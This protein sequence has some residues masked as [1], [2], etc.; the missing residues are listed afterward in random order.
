MNDRASSLF[1]ALALLAGF[2]LTGCGRSSGPDRHEHAAASAA[3]TYQCP[4]H[5]WI[6]SDKADAK[7]TICGMALVAAS[8]TTTSASAAVDPNLVTLTPAQAAV[9]GV[10]TSPVRRGT[11]VRTLRVTGAIDDDDTRHRILAARVPGRVEKL[12]VNF[13]GAEVQEGTQ[14]A[15]IYS[16]DM[17]T[18]QREYLERMKAGAIAFTAAERA[19]AKEKLLGLGLT[20]E[21]ISI[22]ENTKQATAMVTMRAPMSGTVVARGAYEGKYVEAKDEIFQIGDFSRMWF[23]FDAA[24]PDLAWLRV[25]QQVEVTVPSLPGK[26]LTAPIAFIDPNLNEATRTA[27]VRVVLDNPDR[28]LR[29]RQTAYAGVLAES[30]DTLLVPRTAVLQ[31]SGRAVVFVDRGNHAYAA[32][33]IAL[34]RTGDTDAEVLSGLRDG[35]KVVTEGALILD[36]QAQLAHA[37][38]GTSEHDHASAAPRKISVEAPKPDAAGYAA[39]KTLAFTAADA[40]D[41]L[42]SDNLAGYQKQLPA[43]RDALTAYVAAFPSAASTPLAKMKLADGSDLDAARRAFEPFSTD[44]ADL[45]KAQHLHHKENLT[46]YQCPM[47]PV[48]GTGRWLSKSKTLRNPFFGSAMLECGEE[49]E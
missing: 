47:S 35:D 23:V 32:Q 4:M 2:S 45:V 42:A 43:L 8:A 11:L 41:L 28:L 14:L 19:A 44:L 39:L 12:F 9:V 7:C 20:D 6:K 36:G 38:V 3:T 21:E 25:G 40:A 15:T 26:I 17:L 46:I 18:A 24:E 29:H 1:I 5:P 49:I 37:A 16:P 27:K 33:E 31:H 34:G 13:V 10:Q 22:L 30:P 48:L